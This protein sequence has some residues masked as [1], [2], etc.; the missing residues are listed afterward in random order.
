VVTDPAIDALDRTTVDLVGIAEAREVTGESSPRRFLHAGPPMSLDQLSGPMRGAIVAA[1]IFEGEARDVGEAEQIVDSGDVEL[2]PCHQRN[3]VGAMAGVVSPH[4]PVVV[5]TTPN[6]DASFSPLNEGLGRAMRFG[7]NDEATIK[8]LEWMRLLLL[9]ILDRAVRAGGTIE[10][11]GLQAEAL[12]RGDECHNRNVAATAA[13]LLRLAPELVRANTDAAAVAE[14]LTWASG[15]PHFFLPFSMAASKAV[16]SSAHGFTGSPI[17]TAIAANGVDVGIQVSGCGDRW[18]LTAAPVGQVK[19]WDGFSPDDGQP[20]MG[21]S[22]I[23]E[24]V[25][26]GA[27]SLS[28]SPAIGSFLG[29][30]AEEGRRAVR[31]VREVCGGTS[32]RYLLA[33]E[34]FVGAPIGI[35]VHKV[36]S[37][38][39]TPCVNTGVAHRRA[40]VGQI[41]AGMIRL[42]LGPFEEAAALLVPGDRVNGARTPE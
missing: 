37:S 42:P 20:M 32:S 5:V 10:L 7:T 36:T 19:C 41:G 24:T 3:G 1:L 4:I 27:F 11:T 8:R 9:P 40:G 6:G 18:F 35:D 12:R 26:L 13:L 30:T 15:N 34:D 29:V 33:A 25:G 17:V 23:T 16:A 38:G 31:E 21:D 2:M 14:V 22:Y 39:R 28:A